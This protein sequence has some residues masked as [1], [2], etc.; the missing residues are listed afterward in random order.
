MFHT[1]LF[2]LKCLNTLFKLVLCSE[3]IK[4]KTALE[5]G[6]NIIPV[7]DRNF[8]WPETHLLPADI[9]A[10]SSFNAIQWVH[11]YQEACVEKLRRFH[12]YSLLYIHIIP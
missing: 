11:E 4:I 12:A 7:Q 2:T 3:I 5:S 1:D 6:A 8:V 9:Q 10:I